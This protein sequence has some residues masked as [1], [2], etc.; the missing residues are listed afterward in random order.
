MALRAATS[1]DERRFENPED[2]EDETGSPWAPFTG[3]PGAFHDSE[4]ARV[5]L[6]SRDTIGEWDRRRFRANVLLEDGSGEDALVGSSVALGSAVLDVVKRLERCVMITRAQ[7]GGIERD[8]SVLRTV[9][10][11]R[12]ACL[13]VGALVVRP[14]D[15]R[16]GDELRF[17][18][19]AG[20]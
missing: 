17:A 18:A 6:V 11:E 5:S 15:V 2:F 12:D 13:A 16:V 1:D 20:A 8:L 10:R 4:R 3:A 14:G 7:A 19:D 9:A